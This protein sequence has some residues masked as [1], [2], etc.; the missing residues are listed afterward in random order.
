MEYDL[1]MVRSATQAQRTA[2]VLNSG[3]FRASVQRL[4]V[5]LSH[6]G[7]AYAE[8]VSAASEA[9]L[10][11]LRQAG[12]TPERVLRHDSGGYREVTL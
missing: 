5:E 12:L 6:Q 10:L 3:G 8:R 1:F 7:C 9:A 4:P 11:R 2:R